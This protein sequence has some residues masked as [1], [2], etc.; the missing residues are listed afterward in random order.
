MAAYIS[1]NLN[2]TTPA[3]QNLSSAFKTQVGLTAA[4]ATLTSAGINEFT[5]GTETAPADNVII[6]DVSRCTTAGT[7]T[8]GVITSGDGSKRAAGTVSTINLTAEGTSTA[9]SSMFNMPLNQRASFRWVAVP[10]SELIIPA[11]NVN[12]IAI[13]A[14][15]PAYVSTVT[16]S[17]GFIE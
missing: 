4:T 1:N 9:N 7:G 6:W 8:A 3:Q 11:T 5:L 13:R 10:G 15:S 14:K 16:C 12:G 2:A 17:A